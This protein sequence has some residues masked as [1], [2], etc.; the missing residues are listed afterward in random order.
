MN[1]V[2]F[3]HSLLNILWKLFLFIHAHPSIFLFFFIIFSFFYDLQI[4]KEF[5]EELRGDVSMHLHREILQLPIFESAS[6]V[7]TV[8]FFTFYFI[9][10][11]FFLLKAKEKKKIK[12]NCKTTNLHTNNFVTKHRKRCICIRITTHSSEC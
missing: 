9:Y 1:A 12:W 7:F 2:S 11:D 4:L 6:Q 10:S 3:I 5:P 8:D